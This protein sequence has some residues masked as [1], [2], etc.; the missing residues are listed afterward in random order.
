[1]PSRRPCPD[2]SELAG[3]SHSTPCCAGTD[4]ASPPLDPTHP[5]SRPP[6]HH[7]REPPTRAPNGPREPDMG[8][9]PHHR[10]THRARPTDWSIDSVENPQTARL[11]PRPAAGRPLSPMCQAARRCGLGMLWASARSARQMTSESR[12][13]RARMAS[14]LVLPL[15]VRRSRK[16]RAGG[17]FAGL[18]EADAVDGSVELAVAG[19]A[20]AVPV[21]VGEPHGR[22]VRGG[23][24]TITPR[25]SPKRSSAGRAPSWGHGPVGARS[26]G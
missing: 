12:R 8:L 10:R 11:R 9:P 4:T 25:C 13:L 14:L 22:R 16:R 19:S 21:D 18:G 3:S 6:A 15:A 24:P 23:T 7:R 5:T 2:R 20:E 1:M 17:W 26:W